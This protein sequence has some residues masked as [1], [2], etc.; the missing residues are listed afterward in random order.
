MRA[1]FEH[2][3]L[4]RPGYILP[5]GSNPNYVSD[6]FKR[7]LT[8]DQHMWDSLN[9]LSPESWREDHLH[10]FVNIP[11]V[12]ISNI[13]SNEDYLYIIM[14]YNVKFFI[15][16]CNQGFKYIDNRIIS[17]INSGRCK[18][19]ICMAWEGTSGERG[20]GSNTSDDFKILQRW[21]EQASCNTSN[22]YF[23]T[24]NLIAK[25]TAKKYGATYNV[26]SCPSQEVWTWHSTNMAGLHDIPTY[27][28]KHN[29]DVFLTY[30]RRPRDHRIMLL[31][32]L[33][34]QGCFNRGI[35]SF[36]PF[37]LNTKHTISRIKRNYEADMYDNIIEN[38]ISQG[39]IIA[40]RN[41]TDIT[42]SVGDLKN[43]QQTFCSIVTET[44]V[45]E[46]TIFFSE[47][48]W[49]CISVGHPF[50]LLSSP[51]ALAK[52]R[53]MGFKT[54]NNFWNEDYDNEINVLLR[55]QKIVKIITQ[56][57][58][59]NDL[60]EL[61][62]RIRPILEHNKKHFN[63]RVCR[64]FYRDNKDFGTNHHVFTPVEE[65]ILGINYE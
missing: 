48:S 24:P 40:D 49:R 7:P 45:G 65:Y 60:E 32:E 30:N 33:Q 31:A 3:D 10:P 11:L 19:Y 59:R 2:Y 50:I 14:I 9:H 52:L 29:S 23:I 16:N 36:N 57:A 43:Y 58:N 53:S 27:K 28:S 1:V 13:N 12:H 62:A 37:D 55:I 51:G 46:D 17:D 35:V 64:R 21:C 42:N 44:L 8:F 38:L 22:V 20:C 25:S 54:F 4:N 39:E 15:E 6:E 26:I 34:R 56:L 47:K 41:T 5:L 63:D 18:L 61:S